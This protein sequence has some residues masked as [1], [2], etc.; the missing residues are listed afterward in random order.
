M[1]RSALFVTIVPL[2]SILIAVFF[3]RP[4]AWTA[5]RIAGVVIMIAGLALLTLA[6]IQLGNS[7]SF[8]P[9]ATQLVTHGLYA[10]IRNPV[11]VFSALVLAGFV[12]YLNKPYLF[13]LFLILIPMQ[14]L[15][16]RAEGRV[17][18]ARF[19]EQYRQYK[20]ATWF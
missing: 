12:L 6:R 1:K 10:R 15:R 9:Q 19:G 3:L 4:A 18:E 20:A 14:V 7:F 16:A 13:L 2:L 11:Y 17:L 5:L 8:K